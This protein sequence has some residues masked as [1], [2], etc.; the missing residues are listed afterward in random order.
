MFSNNGTLIYQKY[1]EYKSMLALSNAKLHERDLS[2]YSNV[3]E[4]DHKHLL[5]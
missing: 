2:I 4:R 5:I 3:C 1:M